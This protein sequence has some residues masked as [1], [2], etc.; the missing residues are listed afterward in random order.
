MIFFHIGF[1]YYRG[2][3]ACPEDDRLI[4]GPSEWGVGRCMWSDAQVWCV[5]GCCLDCLT[6]STWLMQLILL[7]Y[8][9]RHHRLCIFIVN[10]LYWTTLYRHCANISSPCL[11]L[12]ETDKRIIFSCVMLSVSSAVLKGMGACW[13]SLD[14]PCTATI[15]AVLVLWAVCRLPCAH[16]AGSFVTGHIFTWWTQNVI[17]L[18]LLY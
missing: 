17:I 13:P 15:T 3:R 6:S 11:I 9:W 12:W 14:T 1:W 18:F 16:S 2:L 5:C 10:C 8:V 4:L 7:I